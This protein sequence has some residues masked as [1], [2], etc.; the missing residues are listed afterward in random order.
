M[1]SANDIKSAL[2]DVRK[3][4]R[5]L[6]LYHRRVADLITEIAGLM[7]CDFYFQ[8]FRPQR[9][10]V[11]GQNWD[12]ALPMIRNCFLF[13]P[14]GQDAEDVKT[15]DWMLAV[16]VQSDTGF[17]LDGEAP[18][19]N[20]ATLLP[21]DAAQSRFSLMVYRSMIDQQRNWYRNVWDAVSWPKDRE[22]TL[23]LDGAIKTYAMSF[24]LAELADNDT[25]KDRVAHF[26]DALRR[27]H[28]VEREW[29]AR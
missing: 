17:P 14:T 16:L 11:Y 13:L 4:Y 23:E 21:V 9:H 8:A 28:L 26:Q 18:G 22:V 1:T 29:S 27:E 20:L 15:G 19:L 24:D 25:V 10:G 2:C 7:R 5:L 12:Q 3:A 6:F